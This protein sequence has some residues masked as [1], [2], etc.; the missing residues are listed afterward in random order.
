MKI[1]K[2]LESGLG[3]ALALT[4][5]HEL[6][7]KNVASAPRMDLLGMT[8]LSKILKKNDSSVPDRAK[9][10]ALTMAGDIIANALYYSLSGA[11]KK[12]GSFLRGSM[13]GLAAG[14]GAVVLPKYIGLPVAPASRT[15]KTKVMTVG[16]YLLGGLVSAGL[17]G[18]L[19]KD[20]K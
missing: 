13:L 14:I 4:V 2:S 18:L 15:N 11:G 19:Q 9:L 20:K 16:L 10:I 3:G 17:L 6:L 12:K 8:T 1:V 7:R 5:V